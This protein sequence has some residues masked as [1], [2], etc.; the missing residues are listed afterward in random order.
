MRIVEHPEFDLDDL[1]RRFELARL[2]A[3]QD[4]RRLFDNTRKLGLSLVKHLGLTLELSDLVEILPSLKTT[5]FDGAWKSHN[6]SYVLERSG[7]QLLKEQGSGACDYWREALDGL[8]M[9]LCDDERLAR[10]TSCGH[11]DSN[12]VDILFQDRESVR[13]APVSIKLSPKLDLIQTCFASQQVQ[14]TFKGL[15][16]NTLYY[17]LKTQ[18]DKPCGDEN[19]NW[20]DELKNMVADFLP[21]L[22]LQDASPLAVIGGE[23]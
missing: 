14:V 1:R 19:K 15:L 10:H 18:G 17:D 23:P 4:L 12:C 16:E 20:H 13:L 2:H 9:G 7:C 5:C 8:V 3:G 11:G 21:D 6:N 22:K